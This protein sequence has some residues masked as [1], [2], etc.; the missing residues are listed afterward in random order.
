MNSLKLQK[1]VVI[2][3][4][5]GLALAA[6]LYLAG[7]KDTKDRV[8]QGYIEGRLV[9]VGA[10]QS[11]RIAKLTVT[12]GAHV[13]KGDLLFSLDEQ[14]ARAQLAKTKAALSQAKAS[15][16]N[17]TAQQQRPEEIA[18]LNA[19]KKRAKALY[20]LAKQELRRIER[21]V[22]RKV[23]STE[24]FDQAR[25]EH[26]Q[27]KAALEEINGKIAVA[28]LP[29]RQELI[30]SARAGIKVA[31]QAQRQAL[32][33]LEKR[34]VKSPVTGWVQ[35]IFFRIGEVINPGQPVVSLLPPANLKALFFVAQGSRSG[36]T[37][38]RKV[39]VT[40]DGCAD[41][42]F[43]H[44][45]FVAQKA[46]FTPPI[47]YGPKERSK[48]VFRIEAALDKKAQNLSPG[49]PVSVIPL[50]PSSKAR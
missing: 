5:L 6:G 15:L 1:P 3:V 34:S 8:F 46:E 45:S 25:A 40:C 36:L 20:D 26:L 29:A 2:V 9:L 37:I 13:N 22:R 32:I 16:A 14:L 50:A 30:S 12:E 43:G 49:Q 7:E 39:H 38:G 28:H 18:V 35:Q 33:Q 27:K 44:I 23:A 17:L 10:E 42:L 41:D 24:R 11:G 4:V 48:L 31:Q 19:S 47:I 21:L